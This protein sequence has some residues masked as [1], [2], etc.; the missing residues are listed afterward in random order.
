MDSPSNTLA[1]GQTVFGHENNFSFQNQ[2]LKMMRRI[3]QGVLNT[4]FLKNQV[5]INFKEHA[6]TKGIDLMQQLKYLET[7]LHSFIHIILSQ[8]QEN[9][10]L[11][12]NCVH[13]LESFLTW[14]KIYICI[15]ICKVVMISHFSAVTDPTLLPQVL[16]HLASI[17]ALILQQLGINLNFASASF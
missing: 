9:F 2:V 11:G 14:S 10:A 3:C 1:L 16:T 17:H 4:Q 12:C 5:K 13:D 8:C 7:K 15:H 6:T